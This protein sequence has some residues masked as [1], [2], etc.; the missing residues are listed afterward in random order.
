MTDRTVARERS[1]VIP[2]C[3]SVHEGKKETC[4]ADRRLG[5]GVAS[6]RQ[7]ILDCFVKPEFA[8]LFSFCVLVPWSFAD[9]I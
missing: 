5:R 8:S 4:V 7:K 6:L 3:L 1:E 9:V 2:A